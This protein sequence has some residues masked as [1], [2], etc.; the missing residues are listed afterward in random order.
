[1]NQS[2]ILQLNNITK[3]YPGRAG[4]GINSQSMPVLDDVS[5]TLNHGELLGLLGPSGCGKMLSCGM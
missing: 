2:V 3:T 5:L 1:M 4:S